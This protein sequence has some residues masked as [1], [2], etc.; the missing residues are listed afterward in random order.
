[1]TTLTTIDWTHVT[2]TYGRCDVRLSLG[3]HHLRSPYPRVRVSGEARDGS[4]PLTVDAQVIG[5]HLAGDAVGRGM[6]LA[7]DGSPAAVRQA[8][9]ALGVEVVAA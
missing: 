8:L 9:R 1:M 7:A 3:V 5:V 2:L 6:S 4:G